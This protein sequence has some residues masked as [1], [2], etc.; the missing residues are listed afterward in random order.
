MKEVFSVISKISLFLKSRIEIINYKLFSGEVPPKVH[1]LLQLTI[2]IEAPAGIMSDK[3]LVLE[4]ITSGNPAPEISWQFEKLTLSPTDPNFNPSKY[5]L[6]GKVKF[7][8]Y[9]SITFDSI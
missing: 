1:Q 8:K 9:F 4:C 7:F 5:L 3:N 2:P 6:A